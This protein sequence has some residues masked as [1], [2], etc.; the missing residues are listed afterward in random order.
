[1]T[2]KQLFAAGA[3]VGALAVGG[4]SLASA[5]TS[6][7]TSTPTQNS[8]QPTTPSPSTAPQYGSNH[9]CPNMGGAPS[10]TPS[11]NATSV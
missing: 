10:G 3:I 5:Q 4:A 11:A 1:M 2:L 9:N 8:T 6:G 7:S